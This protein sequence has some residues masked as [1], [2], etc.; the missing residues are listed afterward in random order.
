M[1]C[2]KVQIFNNCNIYKFDSRGNEVQ[3]EFWLRLL[4]FSSE[5]SVFLSV[6]CKI[7]KTVK[8]SS[9]YKDVGTA[10][11]QISVTTQAS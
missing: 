2:G 4:P 8:F 5:P 3:T 7:V 11:I 10:H 1:K 9:D 6:L